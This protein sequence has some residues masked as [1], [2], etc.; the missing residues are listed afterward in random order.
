MAMDYVES[1][2]THATTGAKSWSVGFQPKEVEFRVFPGPGGTFTDPRWSYCIVDTAGG[3]QICDSVSIYSSR[4]QERFTDRCASIWTWN[5]S[6]WT[7]AFKITWD[8][9]T[10][11]TVEYTV[12]TASSTYQ[13]QRIARA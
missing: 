6:S 1:T 11:T 4:R 5:G 8:S 10:A 3:N 12:N 13:V 9:V 7:E 2:I